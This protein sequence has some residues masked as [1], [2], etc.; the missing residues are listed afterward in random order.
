MTPWSRRPARA[1]LLLLLLF[2]S[3]AVSR[4][5]H[6]D[7]DKNIALFNEYNR[8]GTEAYIKQDYQ[9][10]IKY[11]HKAYSIKPEPLLFYNIA[12]SYRKINHDSEAITFY[13]SYL[14]RPETTDPELRAKAEGYLAELRGRHVAE[15]QV[16]YVEDTR[17]PRPKWRI[18]LGAGLV[19]ASVVLLGFGGRA[20]YLDGGCTDSAVSPRQKCSDVLNTGP[21]GAGLVAAGAVLAIGGAITIALPGRRTQ[22][23]RP[24]AVPDRQPGVVTPMAAI[25]PALTMGPSDAVRAF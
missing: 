1:A 23:Q 2:A 14:R 3:L 15:P 21:L 4:L 25:F 6:A 8:S 22:V 19:A 11:F 5:C 7:E 9:A 12:Q 17:A 24:A 16:V 10:A 18:G 20:L 13:Q